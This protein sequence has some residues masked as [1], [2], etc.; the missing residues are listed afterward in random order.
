MRFFVRLFRLE[1]GVPPRTARERRKKEKELKK[2][3]RE[4]TDFRF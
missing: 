1:S 4:K 3:E 2:K